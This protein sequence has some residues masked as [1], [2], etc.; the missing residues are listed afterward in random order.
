MRAVAH[1]A[2]SPGHTPCAAAE[3]AFAEAKAFLCSAEAQQMSGERP[4]TRAAPAGPGVDAQAPARTP[5]STPSEEGCRSGRGGRRCRMLAAPA[6][7]PR[8]VAFVDGAQT[9]LDLASAAVWAID[10]IPAAEYVGKTPSVFH[11]S[12]GVIEGCAG[13]WSET[14]WS[15]P[16]PGGAWL[17]VELTLKPRAA[18]SQP[19]LPVF[20]AYCNA[21]TR[22]H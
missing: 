6:R 19:G 22:E 14:E 21:T 15:L 11:R 9:Q 1:N 7:T 18:T 16:A 17:G 12:T 13:T 3:A 5:R 2:A 10:T 4:R 8:W 20:D